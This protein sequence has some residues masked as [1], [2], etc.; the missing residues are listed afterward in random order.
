MD[1]FRIVYNN[2]IHNGVGKYPDDRLK[3]LN[4]EILEQKKM[5][6]IL[7]CLNLLMQ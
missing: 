3:K 7:F 4:L 1:I 2:F 6:V 5:E